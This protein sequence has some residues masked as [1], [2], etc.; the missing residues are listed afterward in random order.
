MMLLP[1]AD[2]GD[3]E[4]RKV[5]ASSSSSSSSLLLFFFLLLLSSFFFLLSSFF[6]LLSFFLSFF[7]AFLFHLRIEISNDFARDAAG[8]KTP[9]WQ[10]TYS[11]GTSIQRGP[12]LLLLSTTSLAAIVV[13]EYC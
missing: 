5:C 13:R 2:I 1:E 6:C 12:D 7:L 9:G 4:N 3:K 8:V 11:A 10:A